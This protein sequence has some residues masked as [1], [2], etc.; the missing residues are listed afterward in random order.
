M[1][2]LRNLLE[3]FFPRNCCVC[4]ELLVGDEHD[5]CSRCLLNLPEAYN[6][7]GEENFVERRLMGRIP[8]VAVTAL[9]TF[10]HGNDTQTLLHQIK[11]QGNERLALTMGRQMGIRLSESKRF[12]DVDLIIPVPLHP[13]KERQRGYNQSLLLCQGITQNFP[14]PIE[15]N[16][17]IRTQHTSS[18]THKNRQQRLENMKGVFTVKEPDRL[19]GKHLLLIDDVI[20]TGATTEACCLSLLAVEGVRISVA[21][22]AV[23]GDT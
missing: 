2:L 21:A 23:T 13:R 10:K 16:N 5:I 20:T 18:Q 22:L 11:Y 12:D 15:Q 3:L 17:L 6:A 8:I 1:K 4:G 7:L 14:R 19:K 9:L